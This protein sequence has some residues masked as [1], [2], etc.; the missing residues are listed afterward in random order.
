MA[1]MIIKDNKAVIYRAN[2]VD[3]RVGKVIVGLAVL[4]LIMLPFLSLL[5][6]ALHISLDVISII[7]MICLFS[8]VGLFFLAF[9]FTPDVTVDKLS[10]QICI[11]YFGHV[12][13]SLC[14]IS[15]ISAIQS[16]LSEEQV[17]YG[18][19]HDYTN[20]IFVREFSFLLKNGDFLKIISNKN[21]EAMEQLTA[22]SSAFI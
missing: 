18:R 11:T 12:F 1:G 20:V 16:R 8:S 19:H 6:P 14:K 13:R 5:Q 21:N 15:D 17:T 4:C 7:G 3:N 10:G 9:A 2:L 22:E